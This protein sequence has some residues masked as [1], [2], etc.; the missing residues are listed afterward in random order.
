LTVNYSSCSWALTS[1]WINH[2][3]RIN[4]QKINIYFGDFLSVLFPSPVFAGE[5]IQVIRR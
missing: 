4:H 5:R 2:S 3:V 1:Y